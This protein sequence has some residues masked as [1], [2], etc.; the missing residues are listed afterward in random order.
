MLPHIVSGG[1]MTLNLTLKKERSEKHKMTGL[2]L[3]L[4]PI[5]QCMEGSSVK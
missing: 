1:K 2:E 3:P 5:L 4:E